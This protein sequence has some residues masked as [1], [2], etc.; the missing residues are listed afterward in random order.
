MEHRLNGY[1]TEVFIDWGVEEK[2]GLCQEGVLE[3]G[4]DGEKEE[5]INVIGYGESGDDSF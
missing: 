4:R 1:N 2:F 3:G 5:N